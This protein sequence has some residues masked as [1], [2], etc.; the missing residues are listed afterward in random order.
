MLYGR[1]A[2]DIIGPR[3]GNGG[4]RESKQG[5]E[6]IGFF[7]V[8]MQVMSGIESDKQDNST[9]TIKSARRKRI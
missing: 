7:R 5:R 4:R 3:D 2:G 8:E 9:V 6:Q 1:A